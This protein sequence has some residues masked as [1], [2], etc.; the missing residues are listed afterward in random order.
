MLVPVAIPTHFAA[1][2]LRFILDTSHSTQWLVLLDPIHI[3][4]HLRLRHRLV[5]E[6]LGGLLDIEASLVMRTLLQTDLSL[7]WLTSLPYRH[8]LTEANLT[9]NTT[10]L[11]W[12]PILDMS[13]ALNL[14]LCLPGHVRWNQL[15]P[16]SSQLPNSAFVSPKDWGPNG[17]SKLIPRT[18]SFAFATWTVIHSKFPMIWRSCSFWRHTDLSGDFGSTIPANP[19]SSSRV[20]DSLSYYAWNATKL[21]PVWSCPDALAGQKRPCYRVFN[22]SLTPH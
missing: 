8:W 10:W 22:S 15:K 20:P 12:T 1:W 21:A 9:V 7:S 14:Q 16:A 18:W 19:L 2:A 13:V 3:A 17:T 5:H 11:W 6:P 4:P